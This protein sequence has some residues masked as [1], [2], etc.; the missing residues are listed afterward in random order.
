MGSP[1]G[2]TLVNFFLGHLEKMLYS[3]EQDESFPRLYLRYMDAI[4][5]VFSP[6][7]DPMHLSK[8]HTS[9]RFTV[10]IGHDKLPFLDTEV[11]IKD[12]NFETWVYRK[13][14]YT[15][16][17]INAFALCPDQWKRGLLCCLL[18]RAW[19]VCSSRARFDE[20]VA[21][22]KDIFLKNGYAEKFF[23]KIHSMFVI[24]KERPPENNQESQNDEEETKRYVLCI[25]YVGK[26]SLVFKRKI[27][28]L[29]KDTLNVDLRCVFTS[30]KVKDFFSLKSQ[31]PSYLASNVVYKYTCQ[32]E[33][34]TFYIGKTN[35]HIVVRAAEHLDFLNPSKYPTAVG[36]HVRDCEA[37]FNSFECGELSY[38]NFQIMNRC[39]SKLECDVREA[40]LIR[41]LKPS[42]NSQLFEDGACV[43]L[44]VFG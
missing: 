35:R 16:V 20:E 40:F 25:P 12:G 1:L 33:T 18:H 7:I 39:R 42:M 21:K 41:Q 38:Q 4:F 31:T 34:G 44:K 22:L 6:G 28:G 8:L 10:E 30:T 2:P 17:H 15:G 11:S 32:C 19:T 14:T 43:T 27:T 23:K 29:F 3:K 26:P 5:V 36:S 9:I 24:R 37:C 13:K